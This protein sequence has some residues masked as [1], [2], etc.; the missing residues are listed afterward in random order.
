VQ[1][2]VLDPEDGDITVET[3]VPE[4]Y[5]EEFRSSFMTSIVNHFT[6]DD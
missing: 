4:V 6:D 3:L 5:A 1:F 2:N